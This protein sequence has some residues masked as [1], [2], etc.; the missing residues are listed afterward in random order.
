MRRLIPYAAALAVVA[1]LMSPVLAP[2]LSAVLLALVAAGLLG[3]YLHRVITRLPVAKNAVLDTTTPQD[4]THLPFELFDL[5]N[6]LGS[7][8]DDLPPRIASHLSFLA[9]ARLAVDTVS[10]RMTRP[11]TRPSRIA[12]PRPF[13]TWCGRPKSTTI[14]AL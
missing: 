12:F 8:G 1:A 14:G 7:G 2:R 4:D 9:G 6:E 11:I 13:G 5:H 3:D 10:I